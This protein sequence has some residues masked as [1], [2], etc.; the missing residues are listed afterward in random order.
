MTII[1]DPFFEL[2]VEN[3]ALELRFDPFFIPLLEDAYLQ[4]PNIILSPNTT[5]IEIMD[6]EGI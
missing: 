2:E 4:S 6:N 5:T 3:F 1:D